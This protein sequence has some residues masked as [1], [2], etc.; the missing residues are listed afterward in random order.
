MRFSDLPL[1]DRIWKKHHKAGFGIPGA[2]HIVTQ[3]VVESGS[4]II[5]YGQVKAFCEAILVLDLDAEQR[6]K[7]L[8]I[9]K[10]MEIAIMDSTK[11]GFEQLHVFV[12]NPEF[13][14]ILK[15]HF[16]F[17]PCSGEIL[18]LNL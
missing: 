1:I 3:G 17:Q 11:Q 14:K 7:I 13:A 10:L 18:V 16:G 5:A 9:R 4:N 15:K 8:A 6:E 2:S 12:H